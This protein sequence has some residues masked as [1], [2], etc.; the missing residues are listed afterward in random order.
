M[1]QPLPTLSFTDAYQHAQ[2]DDFLMDIMWNLIKNDSKALK[3]N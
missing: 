1:G 2:T 3:K